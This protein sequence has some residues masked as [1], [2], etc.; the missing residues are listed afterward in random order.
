LENVRLVPYKFQGHDRY[1]DE[2][3]KIAKVE[4]ERRGASEPGFHE[5]ISRRV[6]RGCW[7]RLL[8]KTYR[9][10]AR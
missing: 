6:R 1:G 9:L 10:A 3:K 5:D 7:Q 8:I 2:K 4:K